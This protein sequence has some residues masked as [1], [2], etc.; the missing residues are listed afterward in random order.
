MS[1][2]SARRPTSLNVGRLGSVDAG[3]GFPRR[4]CGAGLYGGFPSRFIV[5][6]KTRWGAAGFILQW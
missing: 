4:I 1:C 3:A 5:R 6:G 2:F